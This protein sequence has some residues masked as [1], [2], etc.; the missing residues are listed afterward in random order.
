MLGMVVAAHCGGGAPER[1]GVSRLVARAASVFFLL[2][3][4]KKRTKCLVFLQSMASLASVAL[5]SE[6]LIFQN[7]E[8]IRIS[9]NVNPIASDARRLEAKSN[10]PLILLLSS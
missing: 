1:C 7:V 4:R 9:Q 5:N 8:R 3:K 10:K 6:M 2:E